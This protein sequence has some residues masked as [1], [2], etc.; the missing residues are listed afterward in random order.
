MRGRDQADGAVEVDEGA[1]AVAEGVMV[2]YGR[3]WG[4]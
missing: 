3:L 4:E 1:L 2:G